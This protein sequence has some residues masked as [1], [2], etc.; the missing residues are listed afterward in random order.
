MGLTYNVRAEVKVSDADI[1][2]STNIKSNFK[3]NLIKI[4]Y[5]LQ[6]ST[7]FGQQNR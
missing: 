2:T 6:S 1:E 7:Y 5:R 4:M 3:L